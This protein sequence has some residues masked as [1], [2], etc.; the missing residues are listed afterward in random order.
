MSIQRII[1]GVPSEEFYST[2]HYTK[3]LKLLGYDGTAKPGTFV[4]C[5]QCKTANM[6]VSSLMP[7]VG[8]MYC[9]KC[10]LSCEGLQLYGQA[11]KITNPETLIERLSEDLEIKQVSKEDKIAYCKFYERYYNQIYKVWEMSR[12]GVYP[13]MNPAASS[14]LSELNLWLN[15][16]IFNKAFSD[17]FGYGYKNEIEDLLQAKIQGLGKTS[18]GLLVMPFYLKPGFISGFGFIGHKDQMYYLNVIDSCVGGFCGLNSCHKDMSDCVYV[19]PH[20]LQAAHIVHKCVI[21]GYNKMSVVAKSPIGPIDPLLLPKP[22]IVWTDDA[23]TAFLKTCIKSKNFK[24]MID[25]TPYIWKPTEKLSKVWEG[26]FMPFIHKRIS[27]NKLLDPLEFLVTELLNKGTVNASNLVDAMELSDFQKNLILS[28]CSDDIREDMQEILKHKVS[29]Q[30]ILI[31]KR[32]VFEKDGKLWISGS[33]EIGDEM[34]CNVIMRIT[35]ICRLKQGGAASLFGQLTFENTEISFQIN[36]EMI[37]DNPAKALIFLAANAGLSKQPFLADSI[38][39]KYLEIIIRLSSP[40]IHSVQNHVG[41]D[42]STGR[43]NLPRISIDTNKIRVG[44]PFVM[45]EIEPPCANVFIDPGVL[46]TSIGSI[47]EYGPETTAYLA[48]MASLI[49]GIQNNAEE[50]SRTGIVLVGGKGSLAEYIFDIIRI[51]M[52]LE[53]ILLHSKDDLDMAQAIASTHHVPVAIDGNRSKPKLL[54]QWLEGQGLNSIVLANSLNASALAADKDW[55]FIRADIPVSGETLALLNS[56]KVFPFFMQ[57]ALTVQSQTTYE[58]LDNLKHLAKSID[59]P[60]LAL[61]AAKAI[62]STKGYI[63]CRSAAVHLLNFIHEGVESGMFQT[64]TGGSSKS[65]YVVIKNPLEDVIYIDL[66]TLLSRMRYYHLPVVMWE[67]AVQ[68]LV[69][70]G[71]KEVSAGESSMLVFPKPIWNTLIKAVKRMKALRRA[72]LLSLFNPP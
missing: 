35:H 17:W 29:S 66:N 41:Y 43:F 2:F 30:P 50:V 62:T 63:N 37:E 26:N 12:E 59:R 28:S 46:V 48:A 39:K 69:Q 20:P 14:R 42:S 60:V 47:F 18:N 36:E 49:I 64:I 52:G 44:V 27:K 16:N 71:V 54:S 57:Y 8:W 53:Y 31:D 32:I 4:R 65:K 38:A 72:A 23:D 25:D 56:E 40:E 33:R 10:K 21:E 15:Q 67:P 1:D 61:E 70:L 34:V 19:V 3:I 45:S 51:D 5:P 13:T 24:V 68:H 22:T 7:F 11:Y 55:T 58:F 6:L 9:D